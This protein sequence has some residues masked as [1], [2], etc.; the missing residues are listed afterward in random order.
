MGLSKRKSARSM[1]RSSPPKPSMQGF[2]TPFE[3]LDQHLREISRSAKVE[4]SARV[5]KE[6]EVLREVLPKADDEEIFLQ[7]MSDVIPL[8]RFRRERIHPPTPAQNPARFLAQEEGEVHAHL[9][10]LVC[11]EVK[12]E[13]SLSD[14]Y[15]DGAV[16]GLSPEVL[17]KL[18]G[19][20]FS[21]QDHVDLHGCNREQA[22]EE[23]IQ[24]VQECFGRGLRCV[25]VVCGRGLNSKD[26]K[27]V[28]KEG[29]V[30]WLTQSPLKRMI[31][32][33]AS[34]RSHDGGAG[35]FYVLLRRNE[36]KGTFT[37]RGGR[38]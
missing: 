1:R 4:K 34:A 5:F 23:V 13:L 37:T 19:G 18:K 11:G 2:Y 16:V 25:L 17:N 7:N 26:K 6:G 38:S 3:G 36:Q 22:R 28:L 35:A 27:P 9:M 31:L 15:T 29:V 14:E 33:F 8:P 32:A 30:R 12:F 10:G 24:F 21:Y 20:E